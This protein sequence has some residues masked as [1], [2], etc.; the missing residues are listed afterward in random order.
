MFYNS[1]TF[2]FQHS[3][4]GFTLV[5]LI[6][7]MTVFAIG[8]TGI[9][10]LLSSTMKSSLYSRH[11]IVVA[12]LLR[13]QIELVNNIRDTNI[14]N[15]IGWDRIP[16]STPGVSSWT[17]GIYS[18]ENNF[19]SATLSLDTEARGHI[20]GSPISLRKLDISQFSDI[21][22]IWEQ[23]RLYLDNESRYTHVAVGNTGTQY[24]SYIAIS[25]LGYTWSTW[26]FIPVL[27]N[28]LN[29]GYI[30]DARV[31]VK[32]DTHYREY[33][34]KTAITDWVK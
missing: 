14:R 32:N 21:G 31:I 25:P 6:V 15:Y 22:N 20:L 23:T 33:D 13:E 34:A 5:E 16:S 17:S 24:A 7:G 1:N 19:T 26:E 11:E 10:A 29:Q 3:Q 12:W 27:K 9:L 28:W 2:T 18:I 30:I 4:R 8:L